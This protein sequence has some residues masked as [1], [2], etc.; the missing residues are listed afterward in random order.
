MWEDG[1][2]GA[3]FEI[4]PGSLHCMAGVRAARTREKTGHSGRDDRFGKGREL[5]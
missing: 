5:L 3:A 1:V 4:K 2:W